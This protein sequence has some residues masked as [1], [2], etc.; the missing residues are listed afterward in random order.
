[1][2]SCFPLDLMEAALLGLGLA[3]YNGQCPVGFGGLHFYSSAA[4]VQIPQVCICRV[5]CRIRPLRSKIIELYF[6]SSPPLFFFLK[7]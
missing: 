7:T 4:L 5:V 3:V 6:F 2:K 1:M